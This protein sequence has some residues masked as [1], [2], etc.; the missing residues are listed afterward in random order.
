MSIWVHQDL[1]VRHIL[2]ARTTFPQRRDTFDIIGRRQV[3]SDSCSDL[4]RSWIVRRSFQGGISRMEHFTM[5]VRV[6]PPDGISL[7]PSNEYGSEIA[8]GQ[9]VGLV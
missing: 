2:A 8:A 6:G 9:P 5:K 3:L 7:R 1:H 4:N